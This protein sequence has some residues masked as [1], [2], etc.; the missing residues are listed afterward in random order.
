MSFHREKYI[1][2]GGPDG[3]NGGKGGDV[4]IEADRHLATLMDFH[5][6]KR[7]CAENGER[8]KGNRRTGANGESLVIKVPTGTV[9]KEKETDREFDLI[10]DKEKI[11]IAYGGKGGRGNAAFATS[12]ERAPRFAQKG[13]PGQEKIITLELKLIADVGL[14]GCPN[15]GKSTFLGKVTRA[16]PKVA[17]YPFTTLRP[18]LGLVEIDSAT[19][20]VL[21][22]IPGLLEGAH[23]GVGLGDDFLRHIERTRIIIYVIDLA[24][25]DGR[26]PVNDFYVLEKELKSYKADL[27]QRPFFIA[28]NKIDLPE[29]KKNLDRF[30]KEVKGK[31]YP[32]SALTGEGVDSLIKAVAKEQQKVN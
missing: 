17:S 2:R 26:D 21:A 8:G 32:L 4:I 9:I 12:T 31:I 22:D 15:A 6:K 19:R 20:F 1:S 7:W 27:S 29:A 30:K 11:I 18:Y 28:L 10:E 3:G 24:G 14:V 25:T 16:K 5:Y 23:K 13:I